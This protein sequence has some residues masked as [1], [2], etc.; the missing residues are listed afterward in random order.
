MEMLC[1][2]CMGSLVS[3]DGRSARCTVHGG[4]FTILFNRDAAPTMENPPENSPATPAAP[5]A[6]PPVPPP[7]PTA[8]QMLAAHPPATMRCV[9]HPSLP[10]TQQCQSCGAYMCDTCDFALPNG[11]HL[12]PACATKP[13]T[14]LGPKRKK[15][16][17]WSFVC[18]AGASAGFVL[19]LVYA[20][21]H[22]PKTAL[23]QQA[24]GTIMLFVTLV[25]AIVGFGFGLGAIDR[26]YRNPISLWIAAGWN[27][28]I[29]AT[30]LLMCIVGLAR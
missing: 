23:E 27:A 6:G 12:C 17:I 21:L 11:L 13:Q 30:F 26:R 10:A 5:S 8:A 20:G 24:I 9:Q 22:P 28:V 1:P 16:M 18:A 4:Q 3:S 7:L 19:T 2:Q 14:A 25:P 29:I 15:A